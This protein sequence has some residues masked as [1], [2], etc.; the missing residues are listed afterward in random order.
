M[1]PLESYPLQGRVEASFILHRM[2][3]L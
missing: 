1:M 2:I 3:D